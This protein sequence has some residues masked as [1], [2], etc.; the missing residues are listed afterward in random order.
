[1]LQIENNNTNYDNFDFSFNLGLGYKILEKVRIN[2]RYFLGI[3]EKDNSIKPSVFS[4]II[5]NKI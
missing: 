1:M 4:L 2:T 5:E 3:I